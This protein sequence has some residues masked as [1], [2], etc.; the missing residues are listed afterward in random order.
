MS[1]QL[2]QAYADACSLVN[3]GEL[4]AGLEAMEALM[5][6]DD[7][8]AQPDIWLNA[9][10]L[11]LN[12]GEA[13]R[14][15]AHL[16]ALRRMLVSAAGGDKSAADH[17]LIVALLAT[18]KRMQ[19]AYHDV[20]ELLGPW[21]E[22]PEFSMD[23]RIEY[24]LA[25][26][27]CMHFEAGLREL[28]QALEADG[29]D[30]EVLCHAAQIYIHLEQYDAADQCL[31][32]VIALRPDLGL[33][34]SLRGKM[35]DARKD[36]S[37]A[38]AEYKTAAQLG[39]LDAEAV[40]KMVI[41]VRR[42]IEW[43]LLEL[44]D[45]QAY[46]H[47]EQ[48]QAGAVISKYR[49]FVSFL[50]S[51][52]P[53]HNRVV[54]DLFVA[55]LKEA[56]ARDQA[57]GLALPALPKPP[58]GEA[59]KRLRIGYMSSHYNSHAGMHLVASMFQHHDRDAFETLAVAVGHHEEN[60]FRDMVRAQVDEFVDVH[61]PDPIAGA[62]ALRELNLDILIDLRGFTEH[63]RLNLCLYKPAHLHVTWLGYPGPMPAGVVDY[64][65][66]DEIIAPSEDRASF[67]P[68]LAFLPT[69]YQ[70]T[71][72]RQPE[73]VPV[74][75][76]SVLPGVPADT[77]VFA[78][79]CNAYK[80]QP[81]LFQVWMEILQAVPDSVLWLWVDIEHAKQNLRRFAQEAGI[82]PGRLIF[83]SVLPKSQHISRVPHADLILDTW[84]CGGHVTT[85]DM[86]WAGVPVL[87]K[88]G[89]HFASRVSQSLLH[90]AD[91][92]DMV[93][94]DAAGYRDKA[95]ALANDPAALAAI[96]E[97]VAAART[98]SALFDTPGRV[99]HLEQLYRAMWQ[100]YVAGE[101]PADIHLS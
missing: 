40:T 92:P 56:V 77:F 48:A 50:A 69:T 19:F 82:D 64:Q 47:L 98:G 59:D 34:H 67:G 24:G 37:A 49:P 75:R 70:M 28:E 14:A 26:A 74:S 32:H 17:P 33:A 65:I 7:A 5:T 4:Q 41:L 29:D 43:P 78:C 1:D 45:N 83:A 42:L 96:R 31:Q 76:E 3:A 27:G 100:R 84:R 22:R 21:V 73:P 72:N 16:D 63:S 57:N 38:F 88:R 25:L 6:R 66:V 13:E 9:A 80:I 99:R 51:D 10:Q 93:A 15:E 46:R 20:L 44:F 54:A 39:P 79:F 94:D 95:I 71:D 2:Q 58:A 87:A 18:A 81:E 23:M 35:L 52:D 68:S 55:D 11:A 12:F 53:M 85:T 89:T 61:D 8:S 101:A 91:L 30:V 36:F 97:R 86:L 60:M 62:A 90:A